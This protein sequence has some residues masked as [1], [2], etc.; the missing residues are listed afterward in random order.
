MRDHSMACKC[1][2]CYVE[3]YEVCTDCGKQNAG[4]L[5]GNWYCFECHFYH[6]RCGLNITQV[7]NCDCGSTIKVD[8]ISNKILCSRTSGTLGYR[9]AKYLGKEIRINIERPAREVM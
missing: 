4:I 2:E 5:D 3:E 8:T 9:N 7:T 1:D 6:I